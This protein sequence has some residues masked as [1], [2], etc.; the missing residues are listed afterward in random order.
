MRSGELHH[1]V[2]LIRVGPETR[3]GY[4]EQT[5]KDIV[6]G[7]VWASIEPLSGRELFQAQQVKADITHRV[8]LRWGRSGTGATESLS[9]MHIVKHRNRRLEIS[10]PPVNVDER[11]REWVLLCTEKRVA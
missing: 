9:A 8:R 5:P 4:G 10:A 7:S 2:D 3:N 6:V 11:N 1:R